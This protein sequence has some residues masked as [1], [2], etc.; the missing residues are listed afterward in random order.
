MQRKRVDSA[1]IFI[2]YVLLYG[3]HYIEGSFEEQQLNNTEFQVA[4][5]KKD[6]PVINLTGM[7]LLKS[8]FCLLQFCSVCRTRASASNSFSAS[9]D[10]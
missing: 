3:L 10:G 2:L 6:V 5:S 1:S 7:R 8:R 4:K 9:V